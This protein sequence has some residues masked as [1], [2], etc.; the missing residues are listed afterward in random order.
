MAQPSNSTVTIDGDKF[1]AMS[2]N[3]SLATLHDHTGMP[4]MGSVQCA[5]E[6]SVDLHDTENAVRH[7]E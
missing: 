2:A 6:V 1:N 3:I 5:I 4:M 7:P